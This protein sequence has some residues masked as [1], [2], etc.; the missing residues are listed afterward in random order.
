MIVKRALLLL[1]AVTVTL[2]PVAFK[3][4]VAVPL[5]PTTTLPKLNVVGETESCPVAAIPVPVAVAVVVDGDA[6]LVKVSVALAAPAVS[7]LKVTVNDVL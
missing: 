1:A 5:L 2:A 4:P 6:L 7:G 3:V